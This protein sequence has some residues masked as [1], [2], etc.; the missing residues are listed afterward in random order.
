MKVIFL[1]IIGHIQKITFFQFD[2]LK[3]DDIKVNY[4]YYFKKMN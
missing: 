3:S 1:K 2:D 4:I